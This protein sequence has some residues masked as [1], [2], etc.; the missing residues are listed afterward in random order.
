MLIRKIGRKIREREQE[1]ESD[2]KRVLFFRSWRNLSFKY[3]LR[4]QPHLEIEQNN[5][6][7]MTICPPPKAGSVLVPRN[8][9]EKKNWLLKHRSRVAIKV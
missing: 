7:S 6:R 9:R 8:K 2:V 1:R 5:Y 3:R 4:R